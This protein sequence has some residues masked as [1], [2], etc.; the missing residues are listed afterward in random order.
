MPTPALRFYA[1]HALTDLGEHAALLAALPTDLDH[2]H[3]L[4]HGVLVHR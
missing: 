2:L 3:A 1:A 4:L